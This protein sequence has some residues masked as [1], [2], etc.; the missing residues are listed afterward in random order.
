MPFV[1]DIVKIKLSELTPETF[2]DHTARYDYFD[3]GVI[4][5]ER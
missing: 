3:I 1:N 4:K 5:A 2:L